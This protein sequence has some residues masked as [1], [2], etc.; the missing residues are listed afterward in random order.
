MTI[1]LTQQEKDFLV[2]ELDYRLK[3]CTPLGHPTSNSPQLPKPHAE[4]Y[5]SLYK[6]ITQHD[7][8]DFIKFKGTLKE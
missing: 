8:S 4:F 3:K 2:T 1:E 6:K 5:N 7:H